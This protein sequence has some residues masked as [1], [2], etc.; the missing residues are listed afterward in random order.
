MTDSSCNGLTG[1]REPSHATARARV[2]KAAPHLNV[3]PPQTPPA[4]A[5]ATP[6]NVYARP[7]SPGNLQPS[8]QGLKI[9][10]SNSASDNYTDVTDD[11]APEPKFPHVDSFVASKRRMSVTDTG[12]GGM[13]KSH[14]GSDLPGMDGNRTPSPSMGAAGRRKSVKFM[15]DDGSVIFAGQTSPQGQG[16]SFVSQEMLDAAL[17]FE[18]SV[19]R[20]KTGGLL[21]RSTW[22]P[23]R[24]L[25]EAGNVFTIGKKDEKKHL[26]AVEQISAI[27][28]ERYPTER[29]RAFQMRV[30]V[31]PSAAPGERRPSPSRQVVQ[32]LFSLDSLA[33]LNALMQRLENAL[34][35]AK[36]RSGGG[37]QLPAEEGSTRRISPS[38]AD[39]RRLL[40]HAPEEPRASPQRRASTPA[41]LRPGELPPG[42]TPD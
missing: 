5:F 35:L 38:L 3:Q 11:A 9:H 31:N 40:Q 2:V 34:R 29:E 13:Q 22:A 12:S 37:L 27:A 21:G 36:A 25:I 8:N 30:S 6:S 24:L 4:P 16:G 41:K 17:P 20:Q 7:P 14:S 23:E 1:T 39:P 18:M 33:D 32:H 42:I 10:R 19:Q 15:G 26:F 28:P